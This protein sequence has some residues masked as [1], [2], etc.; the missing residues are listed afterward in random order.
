MLGPV[1]PRR[2]RQWDEI[3]DLFRT[4]VDTKLTA[5]LAWLDAQPDDPWA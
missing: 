3:A 2:W 4:P 1:A 5:D